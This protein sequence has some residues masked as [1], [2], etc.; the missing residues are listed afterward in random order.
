[1]PCL[2]CH[3]PCPALILYAPLKLVIVPVSFE[4][5][6]KTESKNCGESPKRPV[7]SGYNKNVEFC[8]IKETILLRQ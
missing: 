6:V 3:I 4:S 5:D 2:R 8:I 1:M 7:H